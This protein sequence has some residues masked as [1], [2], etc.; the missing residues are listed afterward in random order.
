MSIL[1]DHLA[2]GAVC[3]FPSE[4]ARRSHLIEHALKSEDGVVAGDS[5]LS[6]DTFRASFLPTRPDRIPTTP[7][8][9]FI[10]AYEFIEDGNPISS[11][12]NPKFP[13]SKQQVLGVIASM[14]PSLGEVLTSEVKA[15][16]PG[17]LFLQLQTV[18]AAY[19]EFLDRNGLFEPRYD[20]V[21][22]PSGWD[23]DREVRIL[24]SD[25]VPEAAVL[26]E[27]LGGPEWLKLIPTPRTDAPTIDVYANHLQEIRSTL[28]RIRDLLEQGVATH[29][30]MICLA[31]GDELLATLEDEAFFYGIPLSVRQGRSPLEYPAGRFFTLLDEVHGDHFSLRSLKN[32]LLEPAIPWKEK[33]RI[34]KFVRLDLGDSILYGSKDRPDYFE[35][36]L[37]DLSLRR[38]YSTFRD[39][40]S[41]I[42]R[43]TSVADL[44]RSL[45]FFRD[46]FWEESE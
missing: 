4:A 35:S 37:R 25:L 13:E 36:R 15:H 42:V 46:A 7:L 27:E 31:N 34:R 16:M 5:A 12:Y 14:L 33:E 38:S 19:R 24:Y 28:R 21:A 9:R 3:V 20:P 32:L 43:A 8:I 29:E 1:D 10:F 11:F 40:L 17:A 18:H 6:F 39:S 2:S 41:A 26:H 23:T 30:I 44:V 45:S 22:V